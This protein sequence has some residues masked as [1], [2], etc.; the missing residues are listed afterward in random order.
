MSPAEDR[1]TRCRSC[2]RLLAAS[3]A[4]LAL[5]A[6]PAAAEQA[7]EP[8][9]RE[10]SHLTGDWGGWR[11]RLAQRGLAP[12]ARYTSGFWSNLRGGFQ[13]GTRY[14]GFAEWW[15]DADLEALLGWRGGSFHIDWYSYHG[16]QPSSEL[17]GSFPTQDVSS[18][19]TATSVRFYRIYLRQSWADGRIAVKAGQ[20]SAD[21]DFF[22]SEYSAALMNF[23]F[24]GLGRSNQVAPFYPLATPGLYVGAHTADARWDGRA[25]VYTADPGPDESSNFGFDYGFDNGAVFLAELGSRRRPFGQPGRYAVGAIG[26]TAELQ[27]YAHGGDATGNFGLYGMVDQRVARP[28]TTRPGLGIFARAAGGP[29]PGRSELLWYADFGFQVS[30]PFPGRDRDTLTVGFS[31]LR[32]SDDYVRSQRAGGENVSRH[33]SVLELTYRFQATGWLSVQPDLQ[34]FFEPH[35]SRR[36]AT[37]IGLQVAI[38]L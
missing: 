34:L 30:R 5:V 9:W 3:A 38:E 26:T 25:G 23:G 21:T 37:V 4:T 6:A 36:D 20:L 19:E 1:A 7:A 11:K 16:G 31:R 14:D 29:L 17:V 8:G 32:F 18:H 2:R 15:L 28:T 35:Y 33:Q 12:G 24:F 22:V 13:T 10:R 27:D